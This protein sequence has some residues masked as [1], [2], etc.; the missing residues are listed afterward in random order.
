MEQSGL[1]LDDLRA[2]FL[3][4]ETG[5]FAKAAHRL[6]SSKSI[7]SRRVARLETVL[8]AQLLQRSARGT[9]LTDA[10]QLYYEQAREALTQ[11]ECAAENLNESVHDIS[12]TIRLTGPVYFGASYLAPALCDFM[13]L[14]P[15]VELEVVFNDEKVDLIR[16]GFDLGIRLGQLPDSS[17]SMRTL[18]SSKRMLVA[19]PAYLANNPPIRRP[20][21]LSDHKLLHYT[22]I[23]TNDL[24]RYS[25]GDESQQLKIVPH[26][27]ANSAAMLM[28]G[29]V[30]GVG[31]TVLPVFVTGPYLQ[32]G[33][34]REV[35]PE[36]DW[37]V[38]PV[39]LLM[40]QGRS[41]P[42]RVRTLIDF[43]LLRFNNR[44]I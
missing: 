2:F 20:E 43:L 30:G 21:D 44:I 41:M 6:D 37:G 16:E 1:D 31:L 14:Y 32:S 25:L 8:A 18:I 3:V 12:G 36:Y 22:G 38:T 27:R 10:G 39:T 42:K 28:A 23:I 9:L 15:R 33:E 24:W 29:V 13:T 40:P 35:L 5:S 26:M 34:V 11:L 7:V 17:M 4:A 19:S